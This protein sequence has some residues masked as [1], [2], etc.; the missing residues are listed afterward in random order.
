MAMFTFPPGAKPS[1]TDCASTTQTSHSTQINAIP[2][3]NNF[4]LAPQIN[5]A[6]IL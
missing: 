3:K 6:A 2:K 5:M 1:G 4:H